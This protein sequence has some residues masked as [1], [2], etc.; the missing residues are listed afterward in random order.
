[1]LAIETQ[2]NASLLTVAGLLQRAVDIVSLR[3]LAAAEQASGQKLE[4]LVMH[5]L[6]TARDEELE[7]RVISHWALSLPLGALLRGW[8]IEQPAA[9][10][11][12]D[13]RLLMLAQALSAELVHGS[14]VTPS[15]VE[16]AA[17][18]PGIDDDAGREGPGGINRYP[19]AL[20]AADALS[21]FA[22]VTVV[23]PRLRTCV[24]LPNIEPRRILSP[25]NRGSRHDGLHA[26][27]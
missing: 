27:H 5:E 6:A 14:T 21:R 10:R 11:P 16:A 1:M 2:S 22:D 26:P 9:T 8:R 4:G 24:A 19:G 17:V 25:A 7:C 12:I 18:E 15:L 23:T 13:V 3:A 20:E